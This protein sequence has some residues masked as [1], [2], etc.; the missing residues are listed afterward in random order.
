VKVPFSICFPALRKGVDGHNADDGYD[1]M[2][3]VLGWQDRSPNNIQYLEH[4]IPA[5]NSRTT[6]S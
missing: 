4:H 6:L 1:S 5:L 3:V 2:G